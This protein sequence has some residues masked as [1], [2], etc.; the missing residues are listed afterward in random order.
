MGCIL[1]QVQ[2]SSLISGFHCLVTEAAALGE[3]AWKDAGAKPG[4][5]IWRIVVGI[6]TIYD[7]NRS[8]LC[9]RFVDM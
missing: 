6:K 3:P 4:L 5:Q 1:K 2:G 9:M 7:V 8:S